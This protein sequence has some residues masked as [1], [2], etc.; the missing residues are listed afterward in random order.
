MEHTITMTN[1]IKK[2]LTFFLRK[3][4]NLDVSRINNF[5]NGKKINY[6]YYSNGNIWYK[7][8]CLN[9]RLHREDGPAF[10]KYYKEGDVM[11]EMYYIYGLLHREDGPAYIDYYGDDNLWE[12]TYFLYGLPHR[13]DGPAYIKYYFDGS[14]ESSSYFINGKKLTKEQWFQQL[15]KSNKLK[16]AFGINND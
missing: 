1:F 10:I 16:F 6:E 7:E 9:G 2:F 14:I 5:L 15:S 12:E 11:R 4:F 13:E 8:Y 3:I